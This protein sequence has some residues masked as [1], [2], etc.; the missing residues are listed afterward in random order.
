M[1]GAV[2]V[3]AVLQQRDYRATD[4]HSGSVECVKRLGLLLAPY[5]NAK[6]S[7]LVV[8]RV[9]AGGELAVAS[10]TWYPS[11]AVVLLGGRA[12]EIRHGDVE[13]AIG[14][15]EALQNLLLDR[16]DAL[17]LLDRVLGQHEAEHLNL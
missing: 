11:L 17:M 1:H 16:Q 10:L 9:R 7:C 14:K 2:L 12:A 8:G 15:P 3:L 5:A 4:R 6:A 13:N